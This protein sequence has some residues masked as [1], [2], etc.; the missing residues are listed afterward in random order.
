MFISLSNYLGLKA[1]TVSYLISNFF[2]AVALGVYHIK[3]L[4]IEIYAKNI[5]LFA[6]TA[7]LCSA[8]MF[9]GNASLLNAIYKTCLSFLCLYLVVTREEKAKIAAFAASK[10]RIL[11]RHG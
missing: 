8:V 10:L 5:A 6:I 4:K 7:L 3:F 11:S 1:V 9:L 2:I